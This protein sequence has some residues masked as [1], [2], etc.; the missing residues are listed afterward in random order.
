MKRSSGKPSRMY[1][2]NPPRRVGERELQKK[3][4][5]LY[6]K[7]SNRLILS[8]LSLML[9][10]TALLVI[11]FMPMGKKNISNSSIQHDDSGTSENQADKKNISMSD[12]N[13][14]LAEESARKKDGSHN[15]SADAKPDENKVYDFGTILQLDPPPVRD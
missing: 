3:M 4:P 9:L 10:T 8:L 11:F 2:L 14:S 15:N 6:K 5:R 7:K 1:G 13:A 12:N